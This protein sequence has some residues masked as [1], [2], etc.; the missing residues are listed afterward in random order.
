MR[1]SGSSRSKLANVLFTRA[2]SQRLAGTDVTTNCLHPGVVRTG[3]AH[4][5]GFAMR[6]LL[7]TIGRLFMILP[8]EGVKTSVYLA[9]SPEVANV[10]GGY[11]DAC[12]PARLAPYAEDDQAAELLWA[13]SKELVVQ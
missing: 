6:L 12:R 8:T 4:S 9:T 3:F 2:L 11:F 10:S 1:H 7:S 13:L 5:S